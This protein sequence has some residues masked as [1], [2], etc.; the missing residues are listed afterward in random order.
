[1]GRQPGNGTL[2]KMG[3]IKLEKVKLYTPLKKYMVKK[4]LGK[5]TPFD[6]PF[7][8]TRSQVSKQ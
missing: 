6:D 8:I 5:R 3:C 2:Q 4:F 1:M 7:Y